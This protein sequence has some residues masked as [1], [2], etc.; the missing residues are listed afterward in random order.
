VFLDLLM[1]RTWVSQGKESPV[2]LST[3][4]KTKGPRT[5]QFYAARGGLKITQFERFMRY[6]VTSTEHLTG[7]RIGVR[8]RDRKWTVESIVDGRVAYF[9]NNWEPTH[10]CIHAAPILGDIAAGKT[11]S[12]KGRIVFTRK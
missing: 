9:F 5:M 4:K 1:Q 10:G 7:D 3:V 12:A 2:K 8:S 11:G 6:G